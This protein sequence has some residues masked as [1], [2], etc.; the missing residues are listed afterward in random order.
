MIDEPYMYRM[1]ISIPPNLSREALDRQNYSLCAS[2]MPNAV[3]AP[4]W[5]LLAVD[6]PIPASM[7]IPVDDHVVAIPAATLTVVTMRDKA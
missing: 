5:K 3:A 7:L 4:G 2:N 6:V 1:Y